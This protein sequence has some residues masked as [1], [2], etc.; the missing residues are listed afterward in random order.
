[1][2][3]AVSCVLPQS[4]SRVGPCKRDRRPE[5]YVVEGKRAAEGQTSFGI[6][7]VHT[8]HREPPYIPGPAQDELPLASALLA[9]PAIGRRGS[10]VSPRAEV[11]LR[12]WCSAFSSAYV[13]M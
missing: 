2:L 13:H 10:A 7:S 12:Y 6:G 9:F 4:G 8:H 3:F 5:S 1:M 11:S